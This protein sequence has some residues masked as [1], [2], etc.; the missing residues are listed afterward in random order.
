MSHFSDIGFDIKSIDHMKELFLELKPRSL[1]SQH[2]RYIQYLTEEKSGAQLFWY[3]E[4]PSLFGKEELT[5]I[6]P[7]FNGKT[8][9]R[10]IDKIKILPPPPYPETT[11]YLWLHGDDGEYPLVVDVPDLEIKGKNVKTATSMQATLF[12]NKFEYFENYESFREKYPVKKATG[13]VNMVG[14]SEASPLAAPSG[15]SLED[16]LSKIAD[17]AQKV[18]GDQTTAQKNMA[19]L[20]VD[21]YT[22][23]FKDNGVATPS[24][25]M[26]VPTGT[27]PPK[28]DPNF[29]PHSDCWCYGKVISVDKKVNTLTNLEYYHFTMKTYGATYDV[30]SGMNKIPHE[31][32]IGSIIGGRFWICAKLNF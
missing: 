2:G 1:R 31:P 13:T 27:F 15:M 3:T 12:P 28:K 29:K 7:A 16:A 4:K 22:T 17:I 14:P 10:E 5:G 32:Q 26:F 20:I 21:F 8:I 19:R 24:S 23:F 11:I 25:E 9:Q 6:S 30:V 18:P